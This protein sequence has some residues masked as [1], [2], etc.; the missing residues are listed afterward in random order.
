MKKNGKIRKLPWKQYGKY[1]ACAGA[2]IVF[3]LLAEIS[4]MQGDGVEKGVLHRNPCG[5]GE[6]VYEFYVDGLGRERI[7]AMVTVP[8]QKMSEEEFRESVPEAAGLLCS[9]ILG[10]N[11][12]LAEVREDLE[13]VREL[14]E[15]GLSVSWESERPELLSHMGLVSDEEISENGETFFLRAVFSDGESEETVEIPVTVFPKTRTEKEKLLETLNSLVLKNREAES[16]LLPE[17]FGEWELTYKNKSHSQNSLLILLGI[18]AAGCLYLKERSAPQEE[19]KRREEGLVLDYPDLVSGFLILTG[20]GFSV[21][22][23]WKKLISD[24]KKSGKPGFHPVYEE[25][26]FALNQMEAGKTEVQAYAEF[27]RRCGLRCYMKFASLLESCLYT[28]GKN[29]RKLLEEEMETAFKARADLARRKGEEAS[30]KLLLPMFGMLGI[31][32]VMVVAPAF[33]SLG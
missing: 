18:A 6:A 8:E 7:E 28:G 15:Y 1:I 24:H 27:G 31:V 3:F 25:M 17:R 12:S 33:L 32:M 2:G 23:A 4:D 30:T 26:E 29:L 5:Q 13:L 20:A 14:P 21:K 19:K 10:K 11:P 9:R 22:Q 16:V